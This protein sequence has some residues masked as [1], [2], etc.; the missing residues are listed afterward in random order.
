M[1]W[2]TPEIIWFIIG[3]ILIIMEFT[4][5]GIL[6]IFFGIGA[7]LVVL[8]LF[9]FDIS[10]NTQIIIFIIGSVTPLILLRKWFKKILKISAGDGPDD[11]DEIKEFK[12]KR[13]VVTEK[14]TRQKP[15]HVEFRGS[16]WMAES[17]EELEVGETVKIVDKKNITL[18]VKS[19]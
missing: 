3:L 7:W 12:G 11:L 17:D 1:D 14:I 18:I 13:V 4:V 9:F 6:T 15:G 16:M 5:P 2:F 10:I 19:I 8:L